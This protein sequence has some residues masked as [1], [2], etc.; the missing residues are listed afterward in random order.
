MNTK[1]F[2]SVRQDSVSTA[3]KPEWVRVPEAVR[4]YGVGRTTLYG[5]ISEGLI[6]SAC[7]RKQGNVR[8]VRIISTASFDQYCHDLAQA[9]L[10]V[11]TSSEPV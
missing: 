5:L 8:G 6:K 10:C 3:S 9:D 2:A 7:I 1:L 4:M 11:A